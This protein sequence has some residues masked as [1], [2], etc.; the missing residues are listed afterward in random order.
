[1]TAE[2]LFSMLKLMTMAAWLLLLFLPAGA[3]DLNDRS[4]DLT[5]STGGRLPWCWSGRH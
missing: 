5:V 1:M 2:Q 3:L 4:N